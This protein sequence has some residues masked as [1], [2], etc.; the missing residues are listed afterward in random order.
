M[1]V[2]TRS[3][4]DTIRE[5]VRSAY[6]SR[7]KSGGCCGP[8]KEEASA[9]DFERYTKSA[10]RMGYS[11][12]DVEAVPEGAN[13]GLGC[14][15]PLMAAQVKPGETVLDLGSGA[16]FDA[17]IAAQAV[18]PEG[19]VIGVDMTPEM[20]A[21]ARVN[22]TKAGVENVEF[23]HGFIEEMPVE[24]DTVDVLIS[25]CVIN[26]SPDKPAVF[27]E[28]FRVLRS[29]GRVAVSDVVLTE[30]L[31]PAVAENMAAYVGCV[32]GA[33][34]L[35]DYLSYM[36]E[37]GF[38]DIQVAESQQAVESLPEDDPIVLSVLEGTGSCCVEELSAE[39]K[40]I[41]SHVLSAKV[42][43]RKP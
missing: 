38:E 6:A 5:S 16:G 2:K 35:D 32:A 1:T 13:L 43:A 25:N 12:D 34:L 14:G 18:G 39:I 41:A 33:S 30:P 7:V 29:G 37:A 20:I 22:A 19:K 24:N 28:A 3:E 40:G 15:A 10:L 27:R 4:Q 9:Q 26:L 21:Q 36:K 8:A 11:Q 17:F 23:R 31:P 42:T